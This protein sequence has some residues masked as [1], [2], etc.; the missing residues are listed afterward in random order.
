MLTYTVTPSVGG[1]AQ[2]PQTFPAVSNQL[3][4]IGLVPGTSYTFSIVANNA[5]GAGPASLPTNA[6]VPSGG[7]AA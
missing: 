3:T 4:V 6:V 7:P 5:V 2:S 1:V